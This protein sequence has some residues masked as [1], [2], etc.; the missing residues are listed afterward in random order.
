MGGQSGLTDAFLAAIVGM[1][2]MVGALY[3]VA[4]VLRLGAEETSGRAEPVLANAVG[5]LRWA[6]GHLVVAFAGAALIM[7]LAACGLGLGYGQDFGPI[8]GACLV[9][10]PAIW[11]IGSPAVLLHGVSPQLAV[12]AWGVAGLVLLIGW[13]G[14]ALDLPQPVMNLSPFSHLP[15]LPGQDMAWTPV[16]LLTSLAVVFTAVGLAGLRRRDMA[17]G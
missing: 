12:A 8:V 10:L 13:I 5:R 17:T 7:L 2:G 6:A 9:Q 11:L 15:K 14:P 3:V 4:S 16:L 1:I